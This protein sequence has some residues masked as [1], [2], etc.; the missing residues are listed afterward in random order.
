MGDGHLNK[1]K[2]CT[3]KD[4]A[5]HRAV[6]LE[7]CRAYDVERAKR[8]ER[9]HRNAEQAKCYRANDKR[10]SPAALKVCRAV[11]SGKLIRLPCERC[12]RT[13]HIHAHHEDYDKPLEVVWLC[14]VCHKARHAE[15]KKLNDVSNT[16][17][18]RRQ[19]W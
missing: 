17:L 8:S 3:K 18:L 13:D 6:N 14:P 15:M 19:R 5:D 11:A 16:S 10:R 12:G 1:C 9:K 7:K 2:E 4:V